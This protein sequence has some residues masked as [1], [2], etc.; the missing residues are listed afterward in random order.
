M[1][2]ADRMFASRTRCDFAKFFA[3]DGSLKTTAELVL[4]FILSRTYNFNDLSCENTRRVRVSSSSSSSAPCPT[5]DPW[6]TELVRG[7][8]Q[9]LGFGGLGGSRC[10]FFQGS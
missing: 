8:S 6:R 4:L 9:E 1:L 10:F 2:A 7:R 5:A 3:L